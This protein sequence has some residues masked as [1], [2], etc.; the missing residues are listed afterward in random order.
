M[1]RQRALSIDGHN[2]ML[3]RPAVFFDRDGV[4]N[5]DAGYVFEISKLKWIDGAPEAVKAVNDAGYLAFVITN[6]SGV[7]RGLYDESDV[8]A[9]H[10]WMAAELAKTGARIDAF[11]YCPYHPEAVL[12][13]YRRASDRRKP[14]PGMIIDLL[15]RFSVDAHRSIL[16]GDKPTDL[17]AA[18]AAGITGHLFRGGNLARFVEPL[19]NFNKL[20]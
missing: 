4:L 1:V 7:A 20:R 15:K 9:L 5:E 16:V 18:R 19:L 2:P 17:E 13:Q 8:N 10:E 12:E 14:G 11:E 3:A 6:Q